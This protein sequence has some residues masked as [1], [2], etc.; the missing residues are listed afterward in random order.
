M[1]RNKIRSHTTETVEVAK[2]SDQ[3]PLVRTQTEMSL[4]VDLE[5]FLLAEPSVAPPPP[6]DNAAAAA[7]ALS[8]ISEAS[9]KEM[10]E[11]V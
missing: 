6:G 2:A 11:A 3:V 8:H 5:S 9:E 4:L 1:R 7:L 10:A